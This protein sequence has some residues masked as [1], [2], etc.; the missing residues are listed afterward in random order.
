MA[1]ELKKLPQDCRKFTANG[2]TYTV[3]DSLSVIRFQYY[4]KYSINFGFGRTFESLSAAI[5]KIIELFNKSKSVDAFSM[6]VN[7]R[8][9]I[10]KDMDK[11]SHAAFYLCALFISAK[12][13]DLTTWNEQM[14]E[15][16]IADWNTEGIDANSFFLLAVSLVNG[17]MENLEA[18]SQDTLE[19]QKILEQLEELRK[20]D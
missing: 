4:E 16:K 7:I 1:T 12:D 10:G 17:F 9:A 20:K 2:E 19:V 5:D 8:D 6:L 14:A 15:K 13:E 3:Q 18:T 11:R